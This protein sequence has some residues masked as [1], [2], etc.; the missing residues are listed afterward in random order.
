MVVLLLEDGDED[1][2]IVVVVVEDVEETLKRKPLP[3]KGL[4]SIRCE[5]SIRRTGGAIKGKINEN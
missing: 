1:D 2:G 4:F 5:A 3:K